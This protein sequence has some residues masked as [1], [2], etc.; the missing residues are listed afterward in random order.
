MVELAGDHGIEERMLV[1]VSVVGADGR[2]D[3]PP[4]G[5]QR[6]EEIA[7]DL[8]LLQDVLLRISQLAQRH[9]RIRELDVNPNMITCTA[10]N[11]R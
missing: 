10:P 4:A 5:H 7:A 6:L 2:R 8:E 3:R 9:P 11:A 1:A